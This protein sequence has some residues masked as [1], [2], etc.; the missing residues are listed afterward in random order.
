MK[1]GLVKQHI[2]DKMSIRVKWGPQNGEIFSWGDLLKENPVGSSED[3]SSAKF[4]QRSR[5]LR[6]QVGNNTFVVFDED[7]NKI[8]DKFLSSSIRKF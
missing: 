5:Q 7:K 3:N 1:H 8:I 2:R 6:E 4:F